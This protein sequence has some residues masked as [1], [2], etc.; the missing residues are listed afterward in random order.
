[1][2][3]LK[4]QLLA[5]FEASF[6]G[7]PDLVTRAPGRVNLI[8]EHTDYNDG[9]V[10]PVAISR[11]TMVAAKRRSDRAVRLIAGDLENSRVEFDLTKITPNSD[12]PWSNYVRGM[13]AI[14]GGYGL[15]IPGADIAILGDMPQ[16][17]GLSSS[18]ALEMA[19]G[20]AFAALA[21]Q[22]TIDRNALAKI[23]Q[24]AEHEFAGCKCGIMDQLVSAS[25]RAGHALLLDCRSL[26]TRHIALPDDLAILIVDSGISRGLVEGEYNFR[27]AQCEAASAHY[28]VLALRDL[29]LASLEAGK[30]GLD[31]TAFRRAR[32]VVSENT[33]THEAAAALEAGDLKTMGE[34]MAASH[35]SMRDDFEITLPA[36]DRLAEIARR[37]VHG[38]G[39][40]RMTGGG[41]GGAVVV[42]CRTARASSVA[43]AIRRDYGAA[44]HIL[45]E[46]A[47][48]GASILA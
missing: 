28:G 34:L 40:A 42:L 48:D 45:L 35:D 43:D 22:P 11:Q 24:R 27:R 5:L 19:S 1:V 29:D 8:G 21:G 4:A 33:R 10:L 25:G 47:C 13:A 7:E 6:G 12:A 31:E 26:E 3:D 14:M 44:T 39:G 37:A 32:H 17:V 2:A 9:F 36:I 23:G 38:E 30:A 20:L 15:E 41:F 46:T 18:A 16:G